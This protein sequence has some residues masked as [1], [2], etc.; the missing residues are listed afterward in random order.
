MTAHSKIRLELFYHLGYE[1]YGG[2]WK[3][4]LAKDLNVDHR[5]VLKWVNGESPVPENVLA[6]LRGEEIIKILLPTDAIQSLRNQARANGLYWQDVIRDHVLLL[7]NEGAIPSTQDVQSEKVTSFPV[8]TKSERKN[9]IQQADDNHTL[10]DE[11]KQAVNLALTGKSLKIIAYAG[12]GKTSTLAAI[13]KHHNRK[14]GIYIAFN[15]SI[16]DEARM[17]FPGHVDCRTGHSL[18][19]RAVGYQYQERLKHRF[20]GNAVAEYLKIKDG[21]ADLPSGA[22]GTMILDTVYRFTLSADQEISEDHVP[23]TVKGV[24]NRGIE[25]ASEILP[26]A[27][28]IWSEIQNPNSSCPISHDTYMKLWSMRNPVIA[29]DYILFDEAQDANPALLQVISKQTSQVIYVGDP[30]Q[31]IYSWRGAVNAMGCIK[32]EQSSQ[33]SLSFRFG[34]TIADVANAILYSQLGA[35]VNIRGIKKNSKVVTSEKDSSKTKPNAV[36]CRTNAIAISQLI[37]HSTRTKAYMIGGVD[38]LINLLNGANDLMEGRRT[39]VKELAIFRTWDE[40][41]EYADSASGIDFKPLVNLVEDYNIDELIIILESIRFISEEEAKIT[42]S[43]VHKAKGREWDN[44]QL[45][46]D[47]RVRPEKNDDEHNEHK[48]QNYSTEEANL[49][50]VAATRARKVL[51]ISY[52]DAAIEASKEYRFKKPKN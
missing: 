13:A 39:S 1:K 37:K 35:T 45:G 31:Q 50:Y 25:V 9:N 17:K 26:F 3:T 49:L 29:S 46:S 32:A 8:K 27:R 41:E 43:T 20:T 16:A 22:F 51:D 14:R 4:L 6:F 11:Q 48:I 36:L 15:K 2:E 40:V 12:A 7:V 34:Q 24:G 52:S 33:L 19:F 44:V 30:Y 5:T 18:A 21:V 47:F 23:T 38:V 42:I 10:T 28:K